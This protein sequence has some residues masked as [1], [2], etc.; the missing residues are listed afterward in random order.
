MKTI[1]AQ[2]LDRE[3]FAKYGVFQDLLDNES[4]A[5]HSVLERGFFPDLITLDFGTTTLPTVSVSD[6]VKRGDKRVIPFM[7]AHLYTCE[8]LM[9][10]DGDMILT[11]G[12]LGGRKTFNIDNMK[13]FIVPKGTFVKLNPQIV[14]GTNFPLGQ[15]EVHMLCMLPGRTFNN[16]FLAEMVPEENRPEV[17]LEG[18][19]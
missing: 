5:A 4:L 3:A 1:K 12:V 15:D 14:H 17:I 2:P 9:P 10:L 6:V 11:V 13:A 16:D 8:G 7:E 19:E 18:E